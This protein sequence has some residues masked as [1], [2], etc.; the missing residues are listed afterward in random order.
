MEATD[1]TSLKGSASST[2]TA[3]YSL[4]ADNSQPTMPISLTGN[5]LSGTEIS[6]SWPASTDNVGVTGYELERCQG[7][8]CTTF[9]LIASPPTTSYVDTN[10]APGIVYSYRVR[11][12]DAVGNVSA[13]SPITTKTTAPPASSRTTLFTDPFDRADNADLGAAY[14]DSYTGFGTRQ[15]SF[16]TARAIGSE[17]T[18]RGTLRRRLDAERSV[19]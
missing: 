13:Y 1:R 6:L 11:A 4:T 15:T 8:G 16:A 18:C 19:E 12:R 5:V 10:T 9:A 17:R 2:Y 3:T 14:T 7:A